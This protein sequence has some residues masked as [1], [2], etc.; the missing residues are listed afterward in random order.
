MAEVSI[1]NFQNI[2]Q[3][4]AATATIIANAVD[5]N[6]LPYT[7]QIDPD[8]LMAARSQTA[9]YSFS[10]VISSAEILAM[11][12]TPIA[13]GLTVPMGYF[14]NI[15]G[16]IWLGATYGSVAYATNTS[17][18]I[19]S[20]GGSQNYV[21][22][23]NALAFSADVLIPLTKNAVTSGK[24]FETGADLEIYVP[25]GNPTAGDSDIVIYG[26]YTLIAI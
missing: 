26:Q 7:G 6:G 8:T 24:G 25:V 5:P 11:N 17:L 4:D 19:R 2:P 16:D 22:A 12:T 13:L 18:R 9:V 1:I 14:P 15:V 23:V 21:S 3:S 10:K 20:V